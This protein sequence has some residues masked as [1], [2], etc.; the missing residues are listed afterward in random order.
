MCQSL[1]VS[2]A[3]FWSRRVACLLLPRC[4]LGGGLAAVRSLFDTLGLH[5]I[6]ARQALGLDGG[7]GCMAVMRNRGGKAVFGEGGWII[8][9]VVLC[10]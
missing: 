6:G 5:C 8:G 2:L 10:R 7:W 4:L 1:V 3:L 9:R